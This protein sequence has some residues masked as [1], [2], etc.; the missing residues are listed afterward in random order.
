MGVKFAR[1]YEDIVS[2]MTDAVP[3]IDRFY[4]FFNMEEEQWEQLS[5]EEKKECTKTLCDDLFFALGSRSTIPVEGGWVTYEQKKHV[6]TVNNGGKV[7][8]IINLV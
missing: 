8:A 5:E 3:N 6:I 7:V 2:D 1:D 4:Q